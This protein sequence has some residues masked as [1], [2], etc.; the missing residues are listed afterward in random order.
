MSSE[1]KFITVI[2]VVWWLQT[3]PAVFVHTLK[4]SNLYCGRCTVDISN[5]YY[6]LGKG[7]LCTIGLGNAV[8][9]LL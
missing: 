1:P 4:I 7:L 5:L 3:F 9:P 8:N 2:F 6:R